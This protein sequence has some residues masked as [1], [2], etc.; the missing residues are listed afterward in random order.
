MQIANCVCVGVAGWENTM[1]RDCYTKLAVKPRK[2]SAILYYSQGK[3][4]A[5]GRSTL[6]QK[7]LTVFPSRARA[8]PDGALDVMSTHGGCPVL[9]GQ[10][11]ASN[12][13]VWN[14][15]MPFGEEPASNAIPVE[16]SLGHLRLGEA[17][18]GRA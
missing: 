5:F 8:G 4:R 11:W 15:P 1:V 13:W 14:K 17:R 6:R 12:L 9:S 3:T 18:K 7:P 16:R 10:K 2:A